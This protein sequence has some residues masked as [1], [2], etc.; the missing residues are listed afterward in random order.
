MTPHEILGYVAVSTA[1]RDK[2]RFFLVVGALDEAHV[3]LC[4]G[5][6]RKMARPKKKKHMHI[7]LLNACDARIAAKLQ[8]G[9][10]VFDGEVRKSL[11]NMGYGDQ[12]NEA[13]EG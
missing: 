8:D 13:E 12:K 1:G 11:A 5:K 10:Q 6:L 9:D 4:D 3:L 2:G 7:K